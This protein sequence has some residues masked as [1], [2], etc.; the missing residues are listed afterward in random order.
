M[1]GSFVFRSILNTVPIRGLG[2]KQKS[3]RLNRGDF[4]SKVRLVLVSS[5]VRE[6]RSYVSRTFFTSHC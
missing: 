3:P 5:Q 4:L 1:S 2:A 6:R